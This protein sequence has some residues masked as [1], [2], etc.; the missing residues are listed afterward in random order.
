MCRE[1]RGEERTGQDSSCDNVVV[2]GESWL[3][4]Q[5]VGGDLGIIGG[6]FLE[7]R[8]LGGRSGS[9]TGSLSFGNGDS[10]VE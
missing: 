6:G 9:G 1:R 7:L 2:G 8:F 3:F 10:D 4:R 5:F